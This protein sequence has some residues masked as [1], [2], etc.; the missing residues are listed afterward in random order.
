MYSALLIDDEPAANNRLRTL[1]SAYPEFT[2]LGA[3]GSIREARELLKSC[4]PGV[5][6]LDVEMPRG[7]GFALL[8]DLSPSTRVVFVTANEEYAVAAFEAGAIDY[9]VKPV[10]PERLEKTIGRIRLLKNPLW[11]DSNPTETDDEDTVT[12]TDLNEMVMHLT[13]RLDGTT[14]HIQLDS[15]A[16]IEGAQNYTQVQFV[17]KTGLALYR[18]RLAEWE[19]LLGSRN[20]K[21]LDRS[22]IIQWTLLRSTEWIQ[23]SETLLYFEGVKEPITVGRR[24]SERLKE[25]LQQESEGGGY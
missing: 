25:I 18:R 21:Q 19:S 24:A 20:F 17:N 15:I 9:L 23:R 14:Q 10:D 12:D 5:V 7:S 6:F 8:G 2:V 4:T 22:L 11:T 13:S 3:A 1:L 16:W